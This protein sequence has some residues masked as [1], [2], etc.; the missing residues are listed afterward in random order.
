LTNDDNDVQ[1]TEGQEKAT[2]NENAAQLDDSQNYKE[3]WAASLDTTKNYDGILVDLRKYGFSILTGLITAGSFLGTTPTQILQIGVIIVTMILIVILYWLDTYYQNLIYGSILR[4]R[5]LE[6]FRL[7]RRLSVYTSSIYARS[8]LAWTLRS[9]YFGFLI[10]VFVL[11]LFAASIAGVGT[12]NI[13]TTPPNSTAV[14][15][16]TIPPRTQIGNVT[17]KQETTIPNITIEQE[18]P[19]QRPLL[20]Q[21]LLSP[22]IQ[23]QVQQTKV[24]T[25]ASFFTKK[26]QANGVISNPL[27]ASFIL[28]VI[29]IGAIYLLV[30]RNRQKMVRETNGK[31]RD[32]WLQVKNLESGDPNRLKYINKLENELMEKNMGLL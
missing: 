15:N 32:C 20:Q 30:D 31:F 2:A 13:I 14:A 5:F 3:E 8:H 9:L 28:S 16:V 23:Q 11:G 25:N 12:S 19:Q 26:I 4:T 7:N 27:I 29:G 22:Q 21:T 18:L 24:I 6:V 10:G 17:I 1:S